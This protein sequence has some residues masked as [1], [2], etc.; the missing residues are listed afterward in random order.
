M[1]QQ[2]RTQIRNYD[3]DFSCCFP[4]RRCSFCSSRSLICWTN[5]S[6]RSKSCSLAACWQSF[7]HSSK[8]SP[9]IVAHLPSSTYVLYSTNRW[10]ENHE[11]PRPAGNSAG[12]LQ[13][14]QE[15]RIRRSGTEARINP[16]RGLMLLTVF[17]G[18]HRRSPQVLTT[19][20]TRCS[21]FH[22]NSVQRGN[23]DQFDV[24]MWAGQALFIDYESCDS[25]LTCSAVRRFLCR[26]FHTS[27][28]QT[29]NMWIGQEKKM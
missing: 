13:P 19:V 17:S 9:C 5:A 26:F 27:T 15:Q 18:G 28:M 11:I 23:D 10:G 4:R 22:E 3:T 24:A 8:V 16:L 20:G 12:S 29:H 1:P 2:R 21:R 14:V 7:C 6:S 25:S